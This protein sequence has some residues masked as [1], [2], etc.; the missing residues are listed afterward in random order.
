ML[1]E[2]SALDLKEDM[3]TDK[4][5]RKHSDVVQKL[6]HQ[7]T[8]VFQPTIALPP[9]RVHDHTIDLQPGVGSVNVRPYCYAQF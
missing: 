7:F 8:D 3:N 2:L 5:G 9:A 1:I 6:L 4:V